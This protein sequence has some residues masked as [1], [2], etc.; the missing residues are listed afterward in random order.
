VIKNNNNNDYILN[1]VRNSKRCARLVRISVTLN[2][3][4]AR[5]NEGRL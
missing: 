3:N 4:M 2:V 5:A 1:I